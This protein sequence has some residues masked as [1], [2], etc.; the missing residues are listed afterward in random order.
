MRLEFW[1]AIRGGSSNIE[2][3]DLLPIVEKDILD[4]EK[5]PQGSG[6][7]EGA[8]DLIVEVDESAFD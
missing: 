4:E 1:E 7:L 5:V 3:S 8:H 2:V 6:T